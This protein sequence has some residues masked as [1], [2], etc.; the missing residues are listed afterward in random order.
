MRF[1]NVFTH[2][3]ETQLIRSN[4]EKRNIA[5][6]QELERDNGRDKEEC[7]RIKKEFEEQK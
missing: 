6:Q 7:R 3:Q 1:T 4:G 2:R 5:A